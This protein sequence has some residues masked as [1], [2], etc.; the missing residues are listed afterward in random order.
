[1]AF[2][3]DA[4]LLQCWVVEHFVN[5][6]LGRMWTGGRG[7]VLDIQYH[8]VM[9]VNIL[10]NKVHSVSIV[11]VFITYLLHISVSIGHTQWEAFWI[12][13]EGTQYFTVI[14]HALKSLRYVWL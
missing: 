14:L 4:K 1:M 11:T 2:R 6:E 12:L 7:P 9:H 3:L 10:A 8:F 13:I 5:D